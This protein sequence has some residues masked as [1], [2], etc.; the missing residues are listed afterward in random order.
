VGPVHRNWL[1][2]LAE[3]ARITT[4]EVGQVGAQSQGPSRIMALLRSS[5]LL[6][7]MIDDKIMVLITW[8]HR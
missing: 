5:K 8:D 4:Y 6:V 7:G 1:A 3:T 2:R